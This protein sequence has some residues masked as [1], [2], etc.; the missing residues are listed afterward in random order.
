MASLTPGAIEGIIS[1]KL[2]V[3]G[4]HRPVLQVVK[5]AT[6][7]NAQGLARE[8]LWLSD[9]DLWALAMAVPQEG[10]VLTPGCFVRLVKYDLSSFFGSEPMIYVM[11]LEI[12]SPPQPRVGTLTG[13][14]SGDRLPADAVQRAPAP[15]PPP[16]V[17]EVEAT[18][19]TATLSAATP[20]IQ[21]NVGGTV[22]ETTESTLARH[23]ATFFG[24]L[25][26]NRGAATRLFVDR[27]PTHFRHVLNYLRS[28]VITA[29]ADDDAKA[30]LL[31]ELEFY[32]LHDFA[33]GLCG[34]VLDLTKHLDAAGVLADRADEVR[35]RDVFASGDAGAIG[36]LDRYEGLVDFYSTYPGGVAFAAPPAVDAG[37]TLLYD[38]LEPKPPLGREGAKAT[39]EYIDQFKENFDA[40]YPQVLTR[41]SDVMRSGQV[42]IAGGSVLLGLTA[43]D[44]AVARLSNLPLRTRHTAFW[45]DDAQAGDVDVFV[46]AE[47]PEACTRLAERIWNVLALDGEFWKCERNRGVINMTKYSSKYC[48]PR[49]RQLVV[50]V[51]L[52]QYASLTEVLTCFDVDCCCVGL[53]LESD[54]R[55]VKN[56]RVWALP[57]AVRALQSGRNIINAIH[58]WPRSPVYEMRLTKYACRGFAVLCPGLDPAS[59]DESRVRGT[60]FD[61]LSGV[62]RL[63]RVA[64]LVELAQPTTFEAAKKLMIQRFGMSVTFALSGI[65]DVPVH[66]IPGEELA[67]T[68]MPWGNDYSEVAVELD[69][70][71]TAEQVAA[72]RRRHPRDTA[73]RLVSPAENFHGDRNYGRLVEASDESRAAVWRGIVD[74]GHDYLDVP[75]RIEWD[76]SRNQR[77]YL[78]V[79]DADHDAIYYAHAYKY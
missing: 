23:P 58:A 79:R 14:P 12:V 55:D 35:L 2:T 73:W 44:P 38:A 52:R 18:F 47:S 9:G 61:A 56:W 75:R 3:A 42:F 15:P 6:F 19:A 32:A 39:C 53:S 10:R 54:W 60:S 77:E 72:L 26:R 28:G 41:L 74:C 7:T 25:A 21:L 46:C 43:L 30:E 1:E 11:D 67:G 50:Q 66:I 20:T 13:Y 4:G 34:P 16:T 31:L 64:N 37:S 65:Y 33:R 40:L 57:R 17:E 63:L 51:V 27:D 59:V 68:N 22:F 5:F 69:P 29:P 49:H 78:N 36:R 76:D 8:K 62:A 70:D 71:S 48:S 24:A 45:S